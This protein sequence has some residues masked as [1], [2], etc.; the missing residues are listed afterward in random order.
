M[1]LR[2]P[3]K[4]LSVVL[5]LAFSS[6]SAFSC[7]DIDGLVDL[8]CDRKLIIAAF[9]DSITYGRADPDGLGYPGRLKLHHFPN[10]II[11]NLGKPGEDTIRGK[12]RAAS[13][14][15]EYLGTDYVIVL[16]GVNDFWLENPSSY[17]T[18]SNVLSI[19]STAQNIG[20]VTLLGNL[21]EIKRS[22]QKGWV[23][24]VNSRLNPYRQIDFYSLGAGIISSDLI[25]PNG[26]GYNQMAALAASMLVAY[27]AANRPVDSDGDGIYDFA[28]T[29]FGSNPFNPDTDGDTLLDGAEVF[30]WGSNP[31]IVDSDGDGFND[32]TEV[33]IMGSNPA[34]PR[35]GAPYLES[36]E[37]L[38]Q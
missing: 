29:R 20:A 8:N 11:I 38:R 36:L 34:D 37:A 3:L 1:N 23:S 27:S 15:P 28:E 7:P 18:R 32:Q 22:S 16:E 17:Q 19:V 26:N 13:T 35:P 31:L 24:A 30:T 21:T 6:S 14:L 2:V 5:L 9:G 10:A 4:L 25:H 33:N 12:S